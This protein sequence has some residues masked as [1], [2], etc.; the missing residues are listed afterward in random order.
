MVDFAAHTSRIINRIGQPASITPA[1][2]SLKVVNGVFLQVPAMAFGLVD[3]NN[4][5]LRITSQDATGIVNGDPVSIGGVA[6]S[7][8]RLA[9]DLPAGDVVLDLEKV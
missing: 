5:T 4:P 6:Y 1:G 8:V 9:D 3:G 2:G 7:V